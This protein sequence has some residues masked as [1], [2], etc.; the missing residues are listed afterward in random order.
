[1]TWNILGGW[2]RLLVD[3]TLMAKLPHFTNHL[4]IKIDMFEKSNALFHLH[5]SMRGN[6]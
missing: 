3:K 4:F 1:M 2:Y 6:P 5:F